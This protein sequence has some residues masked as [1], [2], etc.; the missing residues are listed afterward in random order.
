MMEA[1]RVILEPLTTEKAERLRETQNVV[2]FRVSPKANKIQIRRAVETL[3]EVAVK[4]VRTSNFTGKNKRWG[5]FVGR[6]PN[7]KKAYVTLE[8]GHVIEIFKGV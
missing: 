5:R 7:W 6:R 1:D 8:E 2:A 3:F 4:D